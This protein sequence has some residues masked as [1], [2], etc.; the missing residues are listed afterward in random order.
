MKKIRHAV[1]LALGI[2][3]S[4]GCS[5][6]SESK[7]ETQ[8]TTASQAASGS[9]DDII[10]AKVNTL[11]GV[12]ADAIANSPVDGLLQ[13][14]AA[15]QVFYISEDGNYVLSG[16]MFDVN[17][18]M[19]DLTD[20]ALG[21]VRLNVIAPFAGDSIEFKADDEKHVLT[22]FTDYTC[23]YCKKLHKEVGTLNEAGITVRY[24]A[25]P[26]AGLGTQ[27]YENMVSIWCAKDPKS[28]LT[29]AKSIANPTFGKED[30]DNTVA[31]QFTAGRKLGL[32]GTPAIIFDDGRMIPGYKPAEVL[33][34]EAFAND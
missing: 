16:H 31:E 2:A 7:P 8:S 21:A 4:V 33:I 23:G 18:G 3:M 25:W 9:R 1:L 6:E 28:A 22:V 19:K 32:R 30:C 11:M 17:D 34:Q 10:N 12:D 26:R 14:T 5:A 24:L 13:V 15:N 20:A 29:R 27:N